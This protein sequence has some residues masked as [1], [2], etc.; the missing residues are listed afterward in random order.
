MIKN[1]NKRI[2][3]CCH[4][5]CLLSWFRAIDKILLYVRVNKRISHF[6]YVQATEFLTNFAWMVE[7][8]NIALK[9]LIPFWFQFKILTKR[10]NFT[11]CFVVF[12]I[13]SLCFKFSL[14][15]A[16][17]PPAGAGRQN[18]TARHANNICFHSHGIW[19]AGVGVLA[20]VMSMSAQV[21]P[22]PLFVPGGSNFSENF[23]G[24]SENFG[25]KMRN[26]CGPK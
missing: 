12:Q 26:L 17:Q 4:F 15:F 16:W 23:E 13:F 24:N 7:F 6:K 25:P 2:I 3:W 1:S 9:I 19:M 11:L 21:M 20:G 14:S 22:A 10:V 8:L 18:S 5:F